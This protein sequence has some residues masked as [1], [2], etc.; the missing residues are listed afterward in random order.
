MLLLSSAS[1]FSIL[2]FSKM[3]TGTLSECQMVW[4][5]IR[6]DILS[7]LIWVQ[8]VCIGHRQTTKCK[9]WFY[10]YITEADFIKKLHT[11]AKNRVKDGVA[12]YGKNWGL[13]TKQKPVTLFRPETPQWVLWQTA[14]TQMKCYLKQHFHR[15]LHC[16]LRQ[17]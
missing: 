12:S 5:Q 11:H 2:T 6:N 9:W 1:F 15:C 17:N 8:T 4:I 13:V 10:L 7:V 3:L 16:L 14:K